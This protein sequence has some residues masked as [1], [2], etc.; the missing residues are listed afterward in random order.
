[1]FTL[2]LIFL[3]SLNTLEQT[4]STDSFSQETALG[5]GYLCDV[6]QQRPEGQFYSCN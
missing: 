1:M 3:K 5:V 6:A 4:C 2:H